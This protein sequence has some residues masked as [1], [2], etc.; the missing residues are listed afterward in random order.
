MFHIRRQLPQKF[1]PAADDV[2]FIR[3]DDQGENHNEETEETEETDG[4]EDEYT[5]SFVGCFGCI[6]FLGCLTSHCNR[7]F[8]RGMRVVIHNLNIFKLEIIDVFNRRVQ[9]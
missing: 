8:N 6:G 3:R 1:V 2:V 7:C 5:F 9:F 4:T